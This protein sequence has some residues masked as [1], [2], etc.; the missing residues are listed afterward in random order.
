MLTSDSIDRRNTVKNNRDDGHTAKVRHKKIATFKQDKRLTRC[1]TGASQAVDHNPDNLSR[2]SKMGCKDG[3]SLFKYHCRCLSTYKEIYSNL[4]VPQK[5][6]IPWSKDWPEE[7][8]DLKLGL[9]VREIRRKRKY[10]KYEEELIALGFDFSRQERGHGWVV[11]KLAFET[12]MRIYGTLKVP[13]RFEV[14]HSSP[15]WPE[16]TWGIALGVSANNI[17]SSSSYSENRDELIRLGF[18]FNRSK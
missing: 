7:M 10:S 5:F 18:S 15:Y 14:P 12:Y 9:T 17:R 2:N 1:S 4:L 13:Q 3:E 6:V 11:I 8:W 16:A